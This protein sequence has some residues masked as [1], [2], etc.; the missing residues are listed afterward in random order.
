MSDTNINETGA[1]PVDEPK[2]ELSMEYV[3]S[4]IDMIIRD[5]AYI[6]EALEA[7]KAI[8]SGSSGDT[9]SPGDITGKAKAESIRYTVHSREDTNRHILHFLERMYNQLTGA[10]QHNHHQGNNNQPG[11][12][13]WNPHDSR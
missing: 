8:P 3:C 10:N 11:P 6:H 12:R 1:M 13:N 4:R 7:L 9:Y 2:A 5:T